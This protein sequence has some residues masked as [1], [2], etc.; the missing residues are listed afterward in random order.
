MDSFT[1]VAQTHPELLERFYNR[2]ACTERDFK[3]G[4]DGVTQL[5]TMLAQDGLLVYLPDGVELKSPVQLVNVSAA[6][7]DFMSVRRVLIV[8]GKGTRG[9]VLF[10]DHAEGS[11]NYRLL[12]WWR[13]L[14]T[15]MHNSICTVLRKP[16]R[17]IR[18]SRPFTWNN[19]VAA[20]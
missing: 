3:Q 16:H 20:A 11:N 9:A 19:K 10:C 4:A 14:P 2:A 13:C 12:G 7:M 6:R 5:N 1:K 18:A 15:R 8:A 17:R